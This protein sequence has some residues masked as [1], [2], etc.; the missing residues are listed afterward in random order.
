ML[1]MQILVVLWM[2]IL[3]MG[4]FRPNSNDAKLINVGK[5]G[6][7]AAYKMIR[8]KLTELGT[9][10]FHEF[11][12]AVLF[13]LAILLWFFRKPQ[14]IPGWAEVTTDMKVSQYLLIR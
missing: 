6:E 2:Q 11:M 14:F 10:T 5:D 7:A 9:I 3:Y 12:V 8:G 13:V 4:L 1:V